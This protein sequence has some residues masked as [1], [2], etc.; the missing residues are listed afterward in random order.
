MAEE[1][2]NEYGFESD[3]V[4]V[5]PFNFGLNAGKAFLTKFEWS[6]TLGKD[7]A[8]QEGLDIIFNINGTDKSYRL[9]PVT[10]AFKKDGT[11][12][13]DRNSAEFKDAVKDFNAKVFHILHSFVEIDTYKTATSRKIGSFKEFCTIVAALLPKDYSK[14]P[15][16]VFMQFQWSP[17]S[18]KSKTY[19]ELPKKMSYGKWV[20]P[21][22]AGTWSKK[23]VENAD[24]SER[25]ALTYINEKG[26]K[27]PFVRNGWF[28]NS[29]FAHQQ[30]D[31]AENVEE[32]GTNVTS[33]TPSQ[34]AAP[35]TMETW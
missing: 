20:V 32:S 12:T 22:Q 34:D 9:F 29:N 3:E 30:N 7:G 2:E 16:D 18:G 35:S 31:E 23:V 8:E 4:K 27:H 10:K 13:T 28:M 5:S 15:L 21:A 6:G 33:E 25:E 1:I 11:E 17:S 24:D 19:L 26:D 14:K